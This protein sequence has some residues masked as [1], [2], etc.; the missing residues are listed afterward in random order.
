M[1]KSPLRLTP[2]ASRP[3]PD[4]PRSFDRVAEVY[5]ATR[6]LPPDVEAA[7]GTGL[8]RL[9][10]A[11]AGTRF[12]EVAAGT[13]RIALPIAR[14]GYPFVGVD[15]SA[16]M[17]A[18]ARRKAAGT[19]L[20][21][22]RADATALPFADAAFDAGLIV[23]VLH[24]IPAWERALGELLRV[25][26]PGGH[27]LYGHEAW[28]GDAA[29]ERFDGRWRAILAAHGAALRGHDA[30][31]EAVGV[32]LRARGLAP[33]TATLATWR[34]RTTPRRLLERYASRTYSSSWAISDDVFARSS[35]ELAAWAR[36]AFPDQ[37]T[38]LWSEARFSVL[39]ARL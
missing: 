25:V 20:A 2:D 26:R 36:E 31:D 19:R 38:P 27:V 4:A 15:L 23:H 30:T 5:D 24:L 12:L 22:A 9:V 18:A 7:I 1:S 17:L 10:G 39:W 21:L 13:G 16:A 32:A 8:P 28:A 34:R 29:R 37:D 3:T 14:R 33:E 11:T 6:G 35:A